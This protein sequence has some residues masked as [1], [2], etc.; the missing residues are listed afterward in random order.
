M[1]FYVERVPATD[2]LST[3]QPTSATVEFPVIGINKP[4]HNDKAARQAKLVYAVRATG[5]PD[6][7]TNCA[8]TDVNAKGDAR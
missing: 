4:G 8:H 3:P 1:V 6:P 2:P 7:G 5:L